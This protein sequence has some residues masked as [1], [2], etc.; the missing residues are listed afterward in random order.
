MRQSATAHGEVREFLTVP[1]WKGA[2]TIL[3]QEPGTRPCRAR[4]SQPLSDVPLPTIGMS[5]LLIAERPTPSRWG[6]PSQLYLRHLF[7][8]FAS[9]DAVGQVDELVSDYSSPTT[10]RGNR[11]SS[12]AVRHPDSIRLSTSSSAEPL[13]NWRSRCATAIWRACS[14]WSTGWSDERTT[15]CGVADVP[16][17]LKDPEN[18]QDRG[19]G[20][21][22][23]TLHASHNVS[24]R[25][26]PFVPEDVHQSQF[27]VG[28]VWSYAT[29]HVQ[30]MN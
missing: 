24:H 26:A 1:S 19:V 15:C 23:G 5:W 11:K 8:V 4:S 27:G 13:K 25:G 21:S 30:L 14:R 18:R 22:A 6:L 3:H 2:E 10:G 20:G 7:R 12:R 17:P 28:Q 29:S 9:D 16:L